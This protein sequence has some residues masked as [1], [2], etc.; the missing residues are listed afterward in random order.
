V[1]GNWVSFM[2][3][4]AI[5]FIVLILALV[6][7]FSCFYQHIENFFLFYPQTSLDSAPADWGLTYNDVYFDTEDGERLHGWFFPSKK[8]APVILF[9]HGNAGNISH[10]LDNIK[11]LTEQNMQVFIFDYRGYGKSSGKPSETGLY[12]DGLAAYDFLVNQRNVS[13]ERLILFGRSLGAAISIEIALKRNVA[14][15]IL[16][17]AFTSSR[18][19]ART[20]SLFKIFAPLLPPHY[21]NLEKIGRITVPKLIVHGED[22][23]IVPFSMGKEIYNTSQPPKYFFS[24]KNAGHNDTYIVGGKKYFETLAAFVKDRKI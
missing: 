7:C 22:D 5:Y 4:K 8:D 19:M 23:D 15:I 6:V 18:G 2:L 13:P 12:K 24:I 17:S 1:Q 20:L 10:R 21:N 3:V 11:L 9:C 16:E 14:A